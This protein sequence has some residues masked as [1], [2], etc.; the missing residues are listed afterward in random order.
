MAGQTTMLGI[1]GMLCSCG[2]SF[3]ACDLREF[4]RTEPHAIKSQVDNQFAQFEWA[5]DVDV[6][7]GQD[8]IWHYIW[9]KNRSAGLGALWKKADIRIPLTAPLAPGAAHCNHFLVNAFRPEPDADAPIVYGTNSQT[10]RAAVY[11]AASPPS[12]RTGGYFDSTYVDENGKRIDLHIAVFSKA[13]PGGYTLFIEKYPTDITI[14]FSKLAP[15]CVGPFAGP[16]DAI[17]AFCKQVRIQTLE[18]AKIDKAS[19]ASVFSPAELAE[20]RTQDY[21]FFALRELKSGHEIRARSLLVTN[22]ELIV[23]DSRQHVLF[24]SNVQMLVH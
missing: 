23:L 14:A 12:Q 8:W 4:D 15:V 18:D 5:T 19:L 10:Q 3:A 6:L 9:N 22:S 1:I 21:L 2:F 11:V 7:S 24:V 16:E 13:S 17:P 20:R